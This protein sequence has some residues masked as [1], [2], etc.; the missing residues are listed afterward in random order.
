M[1]MTMLGIIGIIA[2]LFV[3]FVLGMPVGFAMAIVGFLGLWYTVSFDAA[4]T[5]AG[6]DIWLTFSNYGLTV[7]PLFIF[8][9]YIAF[10]SGIAERLYDA[11]YKWFGHW[12][13]GLAV[14]TIGADLW[15]Q[16]SYRCY[17]G[18]SCIATDD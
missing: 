10:N 8:M 2:L 5:M 13:G 14:A 16:Y 1:S 17:N 4:I 6:T 11:A 18:G 15:I 9:G 7:V 3:L 12:R